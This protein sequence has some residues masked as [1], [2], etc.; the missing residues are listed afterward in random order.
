[1][2]LT[3]SAWANLSQEDGGPPSREDHVVPGGHIEDDGF[4]VGEVSP[5]G[6]REAVPEARLFLRDVLELHQAF[7]E[8][9]GGLGDDLPV[10]ELP[11]KGPGQF[12]PDF[13]PQAPE[14]L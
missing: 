1:M 13:I 14:R 5:L 9:L 8:P 12:A 11:A 3:R 10:R 6:V 4:H 7:A 2:I